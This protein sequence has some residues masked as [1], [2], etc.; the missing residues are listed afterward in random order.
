MHICSLAANV[1]NFSNNNN[2]GCCF[3][4]YLLAKWDFY[5]Q[6]LQLKNAMITNCCKMTVAH[7]LKVLFLTNFHYATWQNMIVHPTFGD[8]KE[9][10]T[11]HMHKMFRMCCLHYFFSQLL[12]TQHKLSSCP[13]VSPENGHLSFPSLSQRVSKLDGRLYPLQGAIRSFTNSWRKSSQDHF[14]WPASFSRM[15]AFA[16]NKLTKNQSKYFHHLREVVPGG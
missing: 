11:V 14:F 10:H 5:L 2:Q 12:C 8:T 7:H 3:H 4:P 16:S 1:N 6:F 9:R 13:P 15:C